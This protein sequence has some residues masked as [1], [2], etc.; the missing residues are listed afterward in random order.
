MFTR[1]NKTVEKKA[2]G[3]QQFDDSHDGVIASSLKFLCIDCPQ[4][5]FIAKN[6]RLRRKMNYDRPIILIVGGD[7][8]H[9][10][11]SVL[12]YARS[13]K[14]ILIRLVAHWSHISA[15]LD[16]CAIGIFKLLDKR[17]AKTNRKNGDMREWHRAFLA[18]YKSAIIP[19][20]NWRV[21]SFFRG[22]SPQTESS[23]GPVNG[24][25]PQ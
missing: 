11:P 3:D 16:L 25:P 17:E 15:P 19:M 20:F 9:V 10:T 4:T 8:P 5:Q 1:K 14:T 18:F 22:I 13:R 2:L 7:A 24:D 6:D 12:A 23:V 21:F